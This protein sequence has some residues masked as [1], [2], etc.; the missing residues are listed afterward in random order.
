MYAHDEV[1]GAQGLPEQVEG[2]HLVLAAEVL[3]HLADPT[4][5]HLLWLLAEGPRD[6]NG[7]TA[8]VE[9]S[10]SSVS[11][12]LGRL[13]FAGLVRARRDGRHMYYSLTSDHLGRLVAEAYRFADH[14]VREIPHHVR[15]ESGSLDK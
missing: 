5:L 8:E 13:R 11:Q 2:D 14:L 10:R 15:A 1:A 3:R 4:R 7:L 12:H 9:A 6:V